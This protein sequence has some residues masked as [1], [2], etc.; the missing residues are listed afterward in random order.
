MQAAADLSLGLVGLGWT[1]KIYESFRGHV[2]WRLIRSHDMKTRIGTNEGEV[3][4]ELRR[5]LQDQVA[6]AGGV[7]G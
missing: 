7:S 6:G 5:L 3:G 2:G 4:A 1:K